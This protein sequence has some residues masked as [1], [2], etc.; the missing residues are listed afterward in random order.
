[1]NNIAVGCAA[2]P[3]AKIKFTGMIKSTKMNP[4][5]VSHGDGHVVRLV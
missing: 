2:E 1:M 4:K 3:F 5:I